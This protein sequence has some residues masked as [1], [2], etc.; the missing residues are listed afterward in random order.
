MTCPSTIHDG[1]GEVRCALD[2]HGEDQDHRRG[3]LAWDAAGHWYARRDFLDLYPTIGALLRDAREARGLTQ[4]QVASSIGLTR[5]S[6][7]NVERGTQHLPLHSWVGMCQIRGLDPA[8]V[9]SRALQGAGPQAEPLPPQPD[10]RTAQLRRRLEAAHR[11]L[12]ALLNT[13]PGGSQ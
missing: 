1:H 13:L 12:G 11:D 3:F 7:A 6:I 9:I 10:K 5:S 4:Q 8:D 2:P